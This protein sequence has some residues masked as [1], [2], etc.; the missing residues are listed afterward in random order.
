[1]GMKPIDE[2]E[3]ASLISDG[4]PV[5]L[6]E[7]LQHQLSWHLGGRARTT[8]GSSSS[9]APSDS[10]VHAVRVHTEERYVPL[11]EERSSSTM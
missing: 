10:H 5:G 7:R 9:S 4:Q 6:V 3:E 8:Q 1:M 2:S 11:Y